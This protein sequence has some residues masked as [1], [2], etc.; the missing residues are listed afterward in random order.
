VNSSPGTILIRGARQLLTLRGA[1]EPRR[2]SGLRELGII[3]DGSI[4]IRDGI[5]LEVGPTRRVENLGMARGA[6]EINAAGRVVMPG[7]VDCHTHLVFPHSSSDEEGE[8]GSGSPSRAFQAITAKRLEVKARAA[9][10]AMA[11]H[12]TTTLEA[13]TGCGLDESGET[14]ILRVLA[15]MDGD[16]L[17]IVPSFLARLG[18][19][20]RDDS[21]VPR[22]PMQWLCDELMPK[23]R[24]RRF[25]R[26][27][28]LFWSDDR[29]TQENAPRFVEASRLLGFPLKVHC[30]RRSVGS[31]IRFA[32]KS[33]AVSADHVEHAT[34]EEIAAL[35]ASRTMATLLPAASLYEGETSRAP[36]RKLVD[37]GAA[38]ALGSNFN[39]Q[40][41]PTP[42]MQAAIALGC[43]RLGL[44][45]AEAISA[46]TVN[47]A[48]AVRSAER[49]GTL[50]CDK[51]AD[52]I[53][54]NIPD[55]RELAHHF[56]SNL[57]HLTIK[58]GR[59]IYREG[60]V[61]RRDMTGIG[62]RRPGI[63]ER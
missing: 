1:K 54:L 28:E 16:P 30:D 62:D 27:A 51:S 53:V 18:E 9:V 49:V 35:S 32:I 20:A 12:G 21:G 52:V 46:A 41:S 7:F 47:A 44:T 4:L 3:C 34:E 61:A 50:E 26:F 45:A 14:K 29:F 33:G 37:S 39:A 58:K 8:E 43:L 25:A 42:S 11:R 48:H 5:L 22:E 40:L 59:V 23:I 38:V 63:G 57:V 2:G 24:R 36:G 19:E 13:K 31:G 55:Y 10:E 17:E 60:D 56:G 6:H 15:A